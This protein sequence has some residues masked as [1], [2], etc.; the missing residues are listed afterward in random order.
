MKKTFTL[1][2]FLSA[3][4]FASAQIHDFTTFYRYNWILLNPAAVN[5]IHISDK[6]KDYIFNAAYRWQWVGIEG[7]PITANARFE[8]IPS[9]SPQS[10]SAPIKWGVF[11]HLNEADQV[12]QTKI[13][14][15]F[16]Y[17]LHFNRSTYLSL[18]LNAGIANFNIDLLNVRWVNENSLTSTEPINSWYPDFAMGAF[19]VHSNNEYLRVGENSDK[20][21]DKFYLGLS[22][23][24]TFVNTLEENTI[25]RVLHVYFLGGAFIPIIREEGNRL[26]LEPSTWV[27]W[28]PNIYYDPW[29]SGRFPIS[30]DVNF[31]LQY[32]DMLWA[33]AAT[34]PITVSTR[35]SV[36]S[37]KT[38]LTATSTHKT[39][40]E[41]EW[42]WVLTLISV[43]SISWA[44][45]SKSW[46][47]LPGNSC[48]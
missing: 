25:E 32:N 14:G 31:R 21:V 34:V 12:R 17:L 11:A 4:L 33:G 10:S 47:P 22:I 29:F 20:L 37:L 3:T 35:N 30:A 1:L 45:L 26:I 7:A 18:G 43:K 28:I 27:R 42:A 48:Q 46:F 16:A 41:L 13:Q 19:L 38:K 6:T 39:A 15:N 36:L 2:F 23:P 9:S 44:P 8:Q 24:Q 40:F 5:H